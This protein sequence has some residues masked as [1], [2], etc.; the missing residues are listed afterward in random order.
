MSNFPF[1]PAAHHTF[2]STYFFDLISLDHRACQFPCICKYLDNSEMSAVTRMLNMLLAFEA[3]K[4]PP[5]SCLNPL[6]LPRHPGAASQKLSC[7][8]FKS[9]LSNGKKSSAWRVTNPSRQSAATDLLYEGPK[10][11]SHRPPGKCQTA[12]LTTPDFLGTD[13]TASLCICS[14]YHLQT[15][16]PATHLYCTFCLTGV[17]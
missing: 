13:V 4:S 9:I 10:I 6:T 1:N 11:L 5:K 2:Q 16:C 17:R 8:L 12:T 3:Q 15:Q 7:C 14:L